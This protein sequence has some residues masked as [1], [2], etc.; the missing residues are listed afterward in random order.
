M[1][2]CSS[3]PSRCLVSP[4]ANHG[5]PYLRFARG[6]LGGSPEAGSG[7]SRR[8]ATTALAEIGEAAAVGG[9]ACLAVREDLFQHVDGREPASREVDRDDE[10][11]LRRIAAFRRGLVL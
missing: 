4:L 9:G 1:S 10:R 2:C 8:R 3:R 11:L 7:K 6:G 5:K